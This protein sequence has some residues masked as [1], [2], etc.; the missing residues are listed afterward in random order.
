MKWIKQNK[1]YLI[2][3][4]ISLL[5]IILLLSKCN[6]KIDNSDAIKLMNDKLDSLSINIENKKQEKLDTLIKE[7]YH[8]KQI[9]KQMGEV[10]NYFQQKATGIDTILIIDNKVPSNYARRK[11]DTLLY[12]NSQGYYDI[13]E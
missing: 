13:P 1:E 6:S 10:K 7:I 11:M 8:E 9:V 5:L 4:S 12:K 2:L 3:H